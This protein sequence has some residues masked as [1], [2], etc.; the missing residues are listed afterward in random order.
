MIGERKHLSIVSN[1]GHS[2]VDTDVGCSS[3]YD[4]PCIARRSAGKVGDKALQ[5]NRE[6]RAVGVELEEDAALGRI[7]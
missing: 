4:T 1:K 5:K 6:V 2:E 3:A 7:R